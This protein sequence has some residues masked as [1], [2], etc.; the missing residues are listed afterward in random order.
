MLLTCVDLCFS[1]QR[2]ITLCLLLLR[3]LIILGLKRPKW[4]IPE[5]IIDR[6]L[7]WYKMNTADASIPDGCI[8]PVC[9]INSFQPQ[10]SAFDVKRCRHRRYSIKTN[11]FW[12]AMSIFTSDGTAR[13]FFKYLTGFA[14]SQQMSL[15]L[16]PRLR[17]RH[18]DARAVTALEIQEE[19]IPRSRP[20]EKWEIRMFSLLYSVTSRFIF[21]DCFINC[22]H[23]K[24]S[25]QCRCVMISYVRSYG[26]TNN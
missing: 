11:F 16:F 6:I 12:L 3:Y 15:Y 21:F 17:C 20:L 1:Q 22:M 5:K 4:H 14:R 8:A 26:L 7:A 25:W 10:T 18:P 13:H 19:E 24:Y 9:T 23:S 2:T